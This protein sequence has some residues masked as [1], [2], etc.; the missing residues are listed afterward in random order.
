MILK[1]VNGLSQ[2]VGILRWMKCTNF[3][4]WNFFE[5]K[6]FEGK[7][8]NGDIT[9]T[10]KCMQVLK[11]IFTLKPPHMIMDYIPIYLIV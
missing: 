9:I 6:T 11:D 3:W 2:P 8:L 5:I 10:E 7:G 1:L 4:C